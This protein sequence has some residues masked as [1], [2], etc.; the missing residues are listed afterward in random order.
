M[1]RTVWY[2]LFVKY[3]YGLVIRTALCN[4]D[5]QTRSR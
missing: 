4:D 2:Y 5:G 3:L 1:P